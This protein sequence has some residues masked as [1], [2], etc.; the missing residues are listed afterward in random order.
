MAMDKR[1]GTL[2][3]WCMGE[4]VRLWAVKGAV[5]SWR[6]QPPGLVVARPLPCRVSASLQGNAFTAIISTR[7]KH[8]SKQSEVPKIVSLAASR[9]KRGMKLGPPVRCKRIMLVDPTRLQLTAIAY[10]G[11][12][13]SIEK[14][15]HST[16]STQ[17]ITPPLPQKKSSRNHD[18]H[19]QQQATSPDWSPG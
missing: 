15:W 19:K 1:C 10:E 14:E 7:F 3:R 17:F 13:L 5:A 11:F 9:L 12:G 6:A 2:E 4:S 16:K 8:L 18:R